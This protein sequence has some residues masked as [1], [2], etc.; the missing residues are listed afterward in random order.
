MPKFFVSRSDIRSN[1]AKIYG[2]DV[3]HITKVLRLEENSILILCDGEGFDYVARMS[4]IEK[5]CITLDIVEKKKCNAEPELSVTL[6]QGIPKGS[7]FEYII[8]K[9]TELGINAIVPV[10]TH[11]SVVRFDDGE[12]K[13][14]KVERFRRIASES[15]KQCARGAI[16]VVHDISSMEEAVRIAEELDL[17][18]VAYEDEKITSLKKVLKEHKDVSSIGIFIGPEGGFEDSEIKFLKSKGAHSVTLGNRIL[19]TETAGQAVLSAI[20]Y[21]FDEMQ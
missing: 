9:C 5:D 20:M 16:P 1:K 15:V 4:E 7:K 8:E 13:A 12:S 3:K 14:K 6:F 18:I 19:R 21:E 2:S 17:I 10:T 11:R